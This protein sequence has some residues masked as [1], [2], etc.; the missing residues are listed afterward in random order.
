[1]ERHP[2]TTVRLTSRSRRLYLDEN[3]EFD[4]ALATSYSDGRQN[5][6]IKAAS[7]RCSAL[8]LRRIEA[9]IQAWLLRGVRRGRE[10]RTNGFGR[11]LAKINVSLVPI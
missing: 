9:R 2:Q 10:T 6:T 1:M 3:E 7:L 8:V 11:L 4:I 5:Q